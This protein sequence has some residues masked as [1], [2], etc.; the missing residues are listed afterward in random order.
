M[1][2]TTLNLSEQTERANKRALIKDLIE[3]NKVLKLTKEILNDGVFFIRVTESLY[4]YNEDLGIYQQFSENDFLSFYARYLT[5]YDL[6]DC[7]SQ[8]KAASMYKTM[9]ASPHVS[10]VAEL[11]AYDDLICL[12]NGILNMDT[13]EFAQH[14][15][16]L[17]FS[18][19][20]EIVY[21]E[22]ASSCPVF[23][24][25]LSTTFTLDNGKPDLETVDSILEILA[26]FLYPKLMMEKMFFL[27]G[28]GSNGKSILLDILKMM[29]GN[30]SVLSFS[31][32][33]D[34][35]NFSRKEIMGKRINISSETRRE[36]FRDE[37]LKKIIS[38]EE[39]IIDIKMKDPIRYKPKAKLVAAGNNSIYFGDTSHGIYRR[40]V[41]IN[42]RNTFCDPEELEGIDEP[43]R[44]RLFP[45][46]PAE[47]LK[48]DLRNELPSI[49]NLLLKKLQ[50]LRA[51]KWVLKLSPAMIKTSKDY[52]DDTDYIAR[53][54]KENFVYLGDN[55]KASESYTWPRLE[56]MYHNWY[57]DNVSSNVKIPPAKTF[58]TKIAVVFPGCESRAIRI[59]GKLSEPIP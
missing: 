50:V 10:E 38:G 15:P 27:G 55:D 26:Y 43:A 11:D 59:E 20:I 36:E 9:L 25:F 45:K 58:K 21:D 48:A 13:Y 56:A 52:Q 16:R 44:K 37:E 54:L 24:K 35:A 5:D 3:K 47:Q 53:F 30:F 32:L 57:A 46:I 19:R 8:H 2:S 6:D 23:I 17:Y 12:K 7:Y 14:T 4:R 51:R 31:A 40:F 41:P 18:N 28:H 29:F 42:F 49:L 33:S 1:S 34:P 22:E 39:M